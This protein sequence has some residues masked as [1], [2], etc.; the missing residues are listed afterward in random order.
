M[1]FE[2]YTVL[3]VV[4]A[5]LSL[6]MEYIPP[7]SAKGD[8]GDGDAGGA[9]DATDAGDLEGEPDE[10]DEEE[11]GGGAVG[12]AGPDGTIRLVLIVSVACFDRTVRWDDYH[13]C[14]RF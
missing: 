11:E 4:Q 12:V 1:L 6:R 13:R 3:C 7:K 10:G 9:Y 5:K 14:N 2:T 8:G